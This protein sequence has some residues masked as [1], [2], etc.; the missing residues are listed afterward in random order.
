M[1]FVDWNGEIQLLEDYNHSN[2]V[3]A[4]TYL[5]CDILDDD[6]GTIFECNVYGSI[7]AILH[8]INKASKDWRTQ[9]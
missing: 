3:D 8:E 5:K 7:D 6:G 4:G 2:V 9:P 1:W